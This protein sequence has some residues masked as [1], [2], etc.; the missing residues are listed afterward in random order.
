M[1]MK[2]KK[3]IFFFKLNFSLKETKIYV[4]DKN[5]KKNNMVPFFKL[6]SK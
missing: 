4:S 1:M 2:I 5:D 6:V 3:S